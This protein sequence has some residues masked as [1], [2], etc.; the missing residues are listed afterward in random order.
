MQNARLGANE[1]SD[2]TKQGVNN[3]NNNKREASAL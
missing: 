1:T 3:N 2:A